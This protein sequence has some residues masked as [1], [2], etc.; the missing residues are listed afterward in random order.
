M[1]QHQRGDKGYPYQKEPNYHD[2]DAF[3]LI[4]A[5]Q[6]KTDFPCNRGLGAPKGTH[7][8]GAAGEVNQTSR[9]C[10]ARSGSDTGCALNFRAAGEFEPR[11]EP[12]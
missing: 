12:L 10:Q 1:L 4:P 6:H 7:E 5:S 2:R 11:F 3:H 8:K 9:S